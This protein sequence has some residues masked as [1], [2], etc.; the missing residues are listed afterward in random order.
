MEVPSL[1]EKVEGKKDHVPEDD[2]DGTQTLIV[3]WTS[4]GMEMLALIEQKDYQTKRS[5]NA[6]ML[7]P[8]LLEWFSV[9]FFQD[10]SNGCLSICQMVR[11]EA[12][13]GDDDLG[14]VTDRTSQVE[15]CAVTASSGGVRGRHSK[16]D[17]PSTSAPIAPGMYYDPGAPGSSTQPPYTVYDPSS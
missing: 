14:V 15:G 11:P 4:E 8:N 2:K 6:L 3:S 9:R 12:R 10:L 13:R 5:K 7:G 17:I 16:S 1:K